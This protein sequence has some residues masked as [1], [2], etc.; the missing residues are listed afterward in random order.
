MRRF[1]P[2]LFAGIG[3]AALVALSFALG[4][5]ELRRA[6]AR[7]SALPFLG[8]LA[9]SVAVFATYALRWRL[10]LRSLG[11]AAPPLHQL[12]LFRASG[13]A[14]ATLVP[15]AQ[16]SG[17]PVRALLLRGNGVS[18]RGAI[19]AV[20]T[21]RLVE[22]IAG[23]VVGPL[24]LAAFFWWSD[25]SAAAA[26]WAL[27]LVGVTLAGVIGIWIGAARG[28]AISHWLARRALVRSMPEE[29]RSATDRIIAF[30]R[31]PDFRRALA[32][33]LAVEVLL[34][35]ELWTLT[36]AFGIALSLPTIGGVLVG[37]GVAQLA[38]IPGALGSLEAVQ[39][40]VLSFAGGGADVGLAVGFLVRLRET[41]WVAVGAAYL[42]ARGIGLTA[43]P[44][45][46]G[47]ASPIEPNGRTA[48]RR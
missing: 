14:A 28:G 25:S 41:I 35:I 29:L 7:A 8:F 19:V 5:G 1:V 44:A 38:P 10:V 42:Y 3:A 23:V 20:A 16:L 47:N 40:G 39:V 24:Y 43:A 45:T 15:S 37:M 46:S 18:W 12:V 21:D 36:R 32:L 33:S 48:S 22:A 34:V 13:H 26:P 31:G 30:M 27:A 2:F 9:V 4:L 6:I 17:E 11:E